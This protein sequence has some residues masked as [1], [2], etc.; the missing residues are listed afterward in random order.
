MKDT[1]KPAKQGA[2]KRLPKRI[3][4]VPRSTWPQ[5][6]EE[7]KQFRKEHGHCNVPSTYSANRPLAKWV[8]N[9]RRQKQ[10]GKVTPELARRLSRLGFAWVL[11]H[12]TVY[13]RDWDTMVTAL[14]AFKNQNGHCCVPR[15][16]AEYRAIA[17]WL[18]EV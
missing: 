14:T 1:A 15:Q 8:S 18:K 17:T 4:S 10:T 6:L 2:G 12:R 11:R 9:V 16:P 7:L 13:R 5:R 3:R